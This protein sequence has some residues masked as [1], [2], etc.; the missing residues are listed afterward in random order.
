MAGTMPQRKSHNRQMAGE[1]VPSYN[2]PTGKN[3]R[4]KA[5][6]IM[7]MNQESLDA[8]IILEKI[9]KLQEE[10]RH[11]QL[12]EVPNQGLIKMN[13]DNIQQLKNEIEYC[14]IVRE[15][16]FSRLRPNA[17]KKALKHAMKFPA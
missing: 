2:R 8:T 9:K 12:K 7:M 1:N 16:V 5:P 13:L 10:N 15:Y 3:W 11:Q 14:R 17:Q 6:Y 4:N